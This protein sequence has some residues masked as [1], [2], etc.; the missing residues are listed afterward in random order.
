MLCPDIIVPQV[1]RFVDSQ[2]Q[3]FF[4]PWRIIYFLP[5]HRRP[6]Q[7]F[8]D[9]RPHRIQIDIQRFQ[10]L[11]GN[12]FRVAGESQQQMLGTDM[13]ALKFHRFLLRQHQNPP[14]P[15]RKSVKHRFLLL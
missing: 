9:L 1:L 3:G 8:N 5:L 2:F 6:T 12:A 4:C 7:F 15:L 13:I 14:R 11:R 10:R